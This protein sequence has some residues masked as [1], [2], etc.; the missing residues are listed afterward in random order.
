M[1]PFQVFGTVQEIA[2]GNRLSGAHDFEAGTSIPSL[3]PGYTDAFGA[4][5]ILIE[6]LARAGTVLFTYDLHTDRRRPVY[7]EENP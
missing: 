2:L 3:R 6:F 7:I 1:F 5:S 4:S